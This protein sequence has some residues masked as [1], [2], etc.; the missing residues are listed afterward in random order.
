[1]APPELIV[2]A[3]PWP[4]SERHATNETSQKVNASPERS[5][6][7]GRGRALSL[8]QLDLEVRE[9]GKSL[10]I[11]QGRIYDLT[12]W[13]PYHP[14]GDL[15][16][17]P[18]IGKDATEQIL[19]FHPSFVYDK[20]IKSFYY[21][22]MVYTE[23]E[24]LL[25][26]DGLRVAASF[27]RLK[28]DIVANGLMQITPEFYGPLV[29]RFA[30]HFAAT[31]AL[32]LY[33]PAPLNAIVGGLA[34]GFFWQQIA[35]FSHDA[36]HGG[37][38]H[39]RSTDSFMGTVLATFFGGLSL[40]WW[41]HSHNVHH[42]ITNH[43][44]HDPDIQH[45]PVFAINKSF[46]DSLFS[47]YYKRT[48]SFDAWAR[49][50]ISMQHYSYLPLCT[51][52]RF[53]LYVLSYKFL[54]EHF[55]ALDFG[56]LEIMG[57]GSFWVWYGLLSFSFRSYLLALVFILVSHGASSILHLQINVSHFGMST[58]NIDCN[59]HFAIRALRTTMDVDCPEWM[60]WFHGGLQFQVIHHLFPRMPRANLRKAVPLVRQFCQENQ[61][62]Y[63]SHTF[64][65]GN[66]LVL[67][68]LREVAEH[69]QF[70]ISTADF[71]HGH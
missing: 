70:L 48:M 41:K 42:I 21:G 22:V 61:L 39:N 40:G 4:S 6:K 53:N 58:E 44:E 14:G 46:V 66:G 60:D 24:A 17:A 30:L 56:A 59:E 51:I 49:W 11:F 29:A 57:L 12:Q 50:W 69:V 33:L 8:A 16:I 13:L 55:R 1:M 65:Q 9:T 35:F 28:A 19:A 63:H 54:Y 32:C 23:A 52:G 62:V 47:T 71:T 2:E 38:T 20:M 18:L 43:P 27:D 34:M 7:S 5:S 64:I 68:Q 37:V 15:A 31:I 36:G 10:I 3:T 45:M 67:S 25:L 26:E